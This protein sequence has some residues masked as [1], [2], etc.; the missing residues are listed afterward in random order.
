M[1][2][3]YFS[4][5]KF[6]SGSAQGFIEITV[7]AGTNVNSLR[8]TVYN[9]D[10]S[11]RSTNALGTPVETI[12]GQDIY[13]INPVTSSSFTGL[14][15]FGAIALDDGGTVSTFLSFEGTVIAT[16]GP[17]NGMTSMALGALA[18][19]DSFEMTGEAP[20]YSVEGAPNS[21]AAPCFV[22]GTMILTPAGYRRIETL[23][24]GDKVITRNSGAQALRWIGSRKIGLQTGKLTDYRPIVIPANAIAPGI[25]A[26]DLF[27]SPNH[28]IMLKHAQCALLFGQSEVLVSANSLVGK[29]GIARLGASFGFRYFHLL[30]DQHEVVTSNGLST[31][32]FHPNHVGL[33]AFEAETREQVLS[34]FPELRLGENIYGPTARLALKPFE[35]NVLGN[36]AFG[37]HE[38]EQYHFAA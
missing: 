24:A 33:D 14:H 25:P 37:R 36:A 31:E 4:E 30:F 3:P 7:D 21:G 8:V 32:S 2:N 35:A 27:V 28:R 23:Q 11:I 9:A 1:L 20:S 17:A 18:S 22:D 38:I 19:S 16:A 6:K 12:T 29:N 13:V 15:K 5:I 34:L 10:G 26:S